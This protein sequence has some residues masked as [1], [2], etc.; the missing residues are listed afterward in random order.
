MKRSDNSD[1]SILHVCA[2]PPVCYLE[3]DE[4]V[5]AMQKGCPWCKREIYQYGKLIKVEKPTRA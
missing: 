1:T 2:G 5:E 4:A 3:D